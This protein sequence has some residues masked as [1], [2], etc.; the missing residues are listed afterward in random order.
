MLKLVRLFYQLLQPHH[1]PPH[2]LEKLLHPESNE[3]PLSHQLS[4]LYDEDVGRQECE[5]IEDIVEIES[6][7]KIKSHV[8][9]DDL[10]FISSIIGF[11]FIINSVS[12]PKTIA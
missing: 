8:Y 6:D 10:I 4:E 9:R 3:D 11:I 5:A 2:P 1:H 12:S 7:N